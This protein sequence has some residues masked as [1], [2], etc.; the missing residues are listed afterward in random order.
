MP[1]HACQQDGANAAANRA[2]E[3]APAS[4]S[5]P[6][7]RAIPAARCALL[8]CGGT[9]IGLTDPTKSGSS[10]QRSPAPD[11]T[12]A[13]GPLV[14][15]SA[16]RRRQLKR[17]RAAGGE[18]LAVDLE[19]DP[20]H[21]AG[22]AGRVERQLDGDRRTGLEA[23]QLDI[24]RIERRRQSEVG[25]LTALPADEEARLPG[26]GGAAAVRQ[27]DG[28]APGGADRRRPE[29]RAVSGS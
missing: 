23:W 10:P 16:V 21:G 1:G 29:R 9:G 24:Q 25:R 26:P 11:G 8:H 14:F 18:T 2:I 5:G 22:A 6:R 4:L 17:R 13:H 19:I 15:D 12:G 3:R 27:R 28:D 20:G 7:I